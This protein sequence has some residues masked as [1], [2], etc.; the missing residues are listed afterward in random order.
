MARQTQWAAAAVCWL[1][2]WRQKRPFEHEDTTEFQKSS[3]RF[4][5]WVLARWWLTLVAMCL[6]SLCSAWTIRRAWRTCMRSTHHLRALR[7]ARSASPQ[8]L[9]LRPNARSETA[10]AIQPGPAPSQ[11][12]LSFLHSKPAGCDSP[13]PCPAISTP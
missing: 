13:Y 3:S 10:Q 2:N 8:K 4:L 1:V 5:W 7:P 12:T 11:K 9:H 6:D